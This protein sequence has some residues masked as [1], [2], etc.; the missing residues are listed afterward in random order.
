MPDP[1]DIEDLDPDN[2]TVEANRS[3]EQ[4]GG[5]GARELQA[6]R[7]PGREYTPE[8]APDEDADGSVDATET[9]R[10]DVGGVQDM[11]P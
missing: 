10:D 9:N 5:F 4:G 11:N 7:D 3:I 1:D 8:I 6:Q 2:E